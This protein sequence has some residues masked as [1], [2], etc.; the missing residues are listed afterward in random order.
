MYM[1]DSTSMTTPLRSFLRTFR[2]LPDQ[3]RQHPTR[4]HAGDYLEFVYLLYQSKY[5]EAIDLIKTRGGRI[6]LRGPEKE[7]TVH[8]EGWVWAYVSKRIPFTGLLIFLIQDPY[9]YPTSSSIPRFDQPG[10]VSATRKPQQLIAPPVIVSAKK[11]C[12]QPPLC[13]EETCRSWVSGQ[14]YNL[15]SNHSSGA[16]QTAPLPFKKIQPQTREVPPAPFPNQGPNQRESGKG[17]SICPLAFSTP[18]HPMSSK[19]RTDLSCWSSSWS[20]IKNLPAKDVPYTHTNQSVAKSRCIAPFPQA[21]GALSTFNITA[22]GTL[23]S[24]SKHH[25]AR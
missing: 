6:D 19:F 18:P 13:D 16:A 23:A 4:E 25:I 22:N 5:S 20:S 8:R 2:L 9:K 3:M 21:R 17:V 11:N 1:G 12:S 7:W 24:H 15:G 14:H 10:E